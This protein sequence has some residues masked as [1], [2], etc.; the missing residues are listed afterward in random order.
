MITFIEAPN[1]DA[2]RMVTSPIQNKL[3]EKGYKTEKIYPS[4]GELPSKESKL[5]FTNYF[6]TLY[7]LKEIYKKETPV[8]YITHGLSPWKLLN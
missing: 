2:Y 4:K 6:W 5:I 1:H 7:R 8:L 3:E